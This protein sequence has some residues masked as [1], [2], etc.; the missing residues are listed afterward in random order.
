MDHL[1]NIFQVTPSF[2]EN[3]SKDNRYPGVTSLVY[4]GIPERGFVTGFTYGLSLIKHPA[5][6]FGRPELTLSV[7][8]DCGEWGQAVGYIANKLRGDCPFSY[9]NVINFEVPIAPDSEMS[10][11]FIFAPSIITK[12]LYADIEIGAD[13]RIN[14]A[15]L[16]PIY[17]SEIEVFN[18][19]GLNEFWHHPDFD[20]YD[21]NR[22]RIAV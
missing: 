16:Y 19:I 4:E 18:T 11:F 22:K 7:K 3:E 2:Y 5:W 13:F 10:A 12:D 21:V 20:M 8:S 1:D 6:K 14:I 9:G 17:E 15:A